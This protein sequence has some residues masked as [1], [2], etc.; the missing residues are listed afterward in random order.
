MSLDRGSEA[1]AAEP[2]A[3][4][5]RPR[6]TFGRNL[7][8]FVTRKPLG[9]FGAAVAVVLI[10]VAAL[11]PVIATHD[12]Y[13][14]SLPDQYNSPGAGQLFG[15][16]HLGRDVFSRIV[17]GARISLYVGVL[18]SFFGSTIGMTLGVASV[19]MGGKTDLSIQRVVDALM[20]F[21]GLILAIAIMSALGASVN[22]VVFA[23]SIAYIPSTARIVRSQALAIKEM[24]YVLAAHAIGAGDWRI[25]L[26]H[27]VPNIFALYLVVVTFHLGGAIIA[28]AGLSFLGV[29][30]PIDTPSWGG[31]LSGATR[32]YISL[33]PWLAVFPGIAIFVVVFSWNVLG[34]ALRDVLDPR[35]RGT[36]GTG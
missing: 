11:A 8:Y 20:A 10:L 25:M 30:S 19:Q 33:A 23:L 7:A 3:V 1:V 18:A 2:V 35:L 13:R 27:I 12:P 24:D 5:L 16:D 28:E 21:P 29:G 22:N 9:T 34:D 15:G 6:R 31:M 4:A 14:T 32:Q 17:Y 26:R 36:G